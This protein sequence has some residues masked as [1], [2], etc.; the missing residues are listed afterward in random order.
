M[1]KN[2]TFFQNVLE[3][4]PRLSFIAFS[5]IIIGFI[6]FAFVTIQLYRFSLN[7]DA[8]SYFEIAKKYSHGH[9]SEAVN[10]YWSPLISWLLVPFV[11][12]GVDLQFAYRILAVLSSLLALVAIRMIL[13]K[14]IDRWYIEASVL[15]I[16][17][18]TLLQWS[19][20]SSITGDIFFVTAALW[21]PLS[22]DYYARKNNLVSVLLLAVNGSLLC[23][24]KSIGFFVFLGTL[25]V[26]ILIEYKKSKFSKLLK[27]YM[28]AG[29]VFLLIVLP[30][31]VAISY[32]YKKIT[33][34]TAG[35]INFLLATQFSAT[36]NPY[37]HPIT[38][39]GPFQPAGNSITAW[40]DPTVFTEMM[41][42]TSDEI[43]LPEKINNYYHSLLHN[44]NAV[45]TGLSV[46]LLLFGFLG[47]Y[48]LHK[49]QKNIAITLALCSSITLLGYL[50]TYLELRYI[51][52]L[53]ITLL[54]GVA[55]V[56]GS[57]PKRIAFLASMALL[58][59]IIAP[60]AQLKQQMYLGY[61]VYK[62]AQDMSK[63]IPKQANVLS[64]DFSSIYYCYYGQ[65]RCHST[66][67]AV[68]SNLTD[69]IVKNNIKY[70]LVLSGETTKQ[71]DFWPIMK[72]YD[73]TVVTGNGIVL[74]NNSVQ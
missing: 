70:F 31:A 50:L 47:I 44:I 27:G 4:T 10:G 72:Q 56:L 14:Y 12:L 17:A 29:L 8:V 37:L 20:A 33:V 65:F 36:E 45:I 24:A 30:F 38:T 23:F 68:N 61:D 46:T 32:K 43:K 18:A 5:T 2:K 19:L 66:V 67:Q 69:Y 55:A 74:K 28:I 16:A 35:N 73:I 71:P 60:G 25:A 64:D 7:P 41:S 21:L 40:E 59:M 9:I 34:S 51:Y 58:L 62:D 49:K 26:L 3:G 48:L 11:W 53:T 15:L 42:Q 6:V 22:V 39:N 54:L 63:V 57:Q 1:K 13:R 52:I